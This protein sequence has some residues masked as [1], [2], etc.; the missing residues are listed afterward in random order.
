MRDKYPELYLLDRRI[1]Q[2]FGSSWTVKSASY[3][4]NKPVY[5]L[6]ISALQKNLNDPI[7]DFVLRGGKRIRPLLFILTLKAFH[8]DY[9]KHL[10]IAVL[11]EIVHN[12]T[13]VLDDIEDNGEL[14]RGKPTCHK[15][16]GLD[17]ATNV[18]ASMHLLP[19]RLIEKNSANYSKDQLVRLWSV[20]T[21]ELTNVSFG[22]AL[23]IYWHKTHPKDISVDKYL[24]MVR[25]KTGSLM[26][27][28]MRMAVV[29]ANKNEKIEKLF[30]DF[31]ENIGIAF[32]IIDDS[33]DLQNTKKGEFGKAVGNDITEGKLSLPTILALKQLKKRKR[34]RLLNILKSHTRNKK[35]ILE[36][37]KIINSTSAIN[38]SYKFARTLVE[39]SWKKVEKSNNGAELA[40]LK[41]VAEFIIKR[42]Y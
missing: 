33:L 38:D 8:I 31:A 3:F 1:R 35:N 17:T 22:Q 39:E 4:I 12:G 28:S 6:H 11:I 24:E 9:K 19:L 34:T 27:M 10:D 29:V 23:D 13:L 15:K 14:R 41:S 37:L 5:K 42:T 21:D 7:R 2:I 16:F 18:G 30:Q 26:R 25:L 36:A 40:E 32:Q 20:Y